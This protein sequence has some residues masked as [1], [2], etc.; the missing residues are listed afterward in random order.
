MK[1][2]AQADRQAMQRRHNRDLINDIDRRVRQV[3][4]D[5][6]LLLKLAAEAWQDIFSL[7]R[8]LTYTK[9]LNIISGKQIPCI[10]YNPLTLPN[11][12]KDLTPGKPTNYTHS[13]LHRSFFRRQPAYGHTLRDPANSNGSIKTNGTMYHHEYTLPC[14][15]F[16]QIQNGASCFHRPKPPRTS[17]LNPYLPTLLIQAGD[18]ELNPGPLYPTTDNTRDRTFEE[19]R[20]PSL[21]NPP[22]PQ[23]DLEKPRDI[24]QLNFCPRQTKKFNLRYLL[25]NPSPANLHEAKN[26]IY[27][28]LFTCGT[29]DSLG[30]CLHVITGAYCLY[31]QPMSATLADLLLDHYD[32]LVCGICFRPTVHSEYTCKLLPPGMSCSK[33]CED[34]YINQFILP[35]NPSQHR[36][37]AIWYNS[38]S[39][40]TID[41]LGRAPSCGV[42]KNYKQCTLETFN[43]ST[44]QTNLEDPINSRKHR[45]RRYKA[46]KK[47]FI[48]LPDS[49]GEV[50]LHLTAGALCA[51][52]DCLTLILGTNKKNRV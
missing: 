28:L 34:L 41:N 14:S 31:K 4:G 6:N 3:G 25:N 16:F 47:N 30:E 8:Y 12:L 51:G 38:I 23:V 44:L 33:N 24:R 52:K 46:I 7:E 22:A 29:C 45:K 15:Y 50:I 49:W 13:L 35:F 10:I 26:T 20:A 17:T 32:G 42:H 18:V 9:K 27:N 37:R 48:P 40:Q 19:Q 43:F 5:T 1:A 11:N 2:K 39:V 36:I 21:G